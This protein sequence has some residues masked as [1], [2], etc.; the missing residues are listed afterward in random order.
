MSIELRLSEVEPPK[1]DEPRTI[2]RDIDSLPD[3]MQLGLTIRAFNY[4][5]V[6]LYFQITGSHPDY[7]F[8]TVNLGLVGSGTDIYRNLDNFA[9]RPRP[10]AETEEVITLILR[11]YTDAG[12]SDLKHTYNRSVTVIIINS[13][14]GSWTTDVENNFDDGTVQGWSSDTDLPAWVSH[15]VSVVTDYVLSS[16]YAL[17]LYCSSTAFLP[18]QMS[19]WLRKTFTTPDKTNVFAIINIRLSVLHASYDFLKHGYASRNGTLLVFLG[20]PYDGLTEHYMV[21]DK[22]LRIVVPLPKNTT[23]E[24]RVGIRA[25]RTSAIYGGACYIRMDDFKIISKD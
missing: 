11:A 23:L 24:V 13:Q 7:T 22:W 21:R 6:G 2:Y 14:N 10:A 4:D 5:D 19:A 16:P 20:R 9:S 18:A 15:S 25:V 17:R 12:Y 8:G 1:P 3:P